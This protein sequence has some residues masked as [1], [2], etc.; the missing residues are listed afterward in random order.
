MRALPRSLGTIVVAV[1]L[2]AGC[3]PAL[4]AKRHSHATPQSPPI[5][6]DAQAVAAC[7]WRIRTQVEPGFDAYVNPGDNLV[8]Y[9]GTA[10]ARF[11]FDRCMTEFG[12]PLVD[13]GTPVP[14]T[15]TPPPPTANPETIGRNAFLRGC[16]ED[17]TALPVCSCTWERLRAIY[18]IPQIIGFVQAK[19]FDPIVGAFTI[20]QNQAGSA[21]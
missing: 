14:A 1:I 8:H 2:I 4:A 16:T 15:T 12:K 13:P 7:R 10:P 20:C 18:S 3:T 6:T 9:F 17:G 21:F 19:T 5:R 11:Q